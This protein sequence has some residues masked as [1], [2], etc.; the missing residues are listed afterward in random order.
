MDVGI[1]EST[2]GL[3]HMSFADWLREQKMDSKIL[4]WYMNY[5]CRDDYG[6]TADQ[7]SA[8]AGIQYFASRD[9]EEKGPLTWPEGNGWIVRRLLERVGRYVHTG[10]MVH[11][12]VP[13]KTGASVFAGD[14]EFQTEFVIFAAPTFLGPYLI[15]G[16]APLQDFEYSPWLTANLTLDRIPTSYGGD[17]TW[18]NVF[19]DSPTLGYV[20]AMHQSLATHNDRRCGPFTGHS[21]KA[22]LLRTV[23]YS[24]LASG[25]IGKTQSCTISNASTRRF[26][27]A[28]RASISCAWGMPWQDPNGGQSSRRNA[29]ASERL[30]GQLY[31]Q[32]LT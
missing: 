27:S 3:D 15:D 6:A 14:T 23:N 31:S 29:E 17:P 13:Q 2:A 19:M 22:P 20:D 10:Q 5:C 7:T 11:R 18:D 16:M 24:W 8:W 30:R 1:S 21:Q 32:T 25:L 12:I 26:A 4:N 9:P 28:S